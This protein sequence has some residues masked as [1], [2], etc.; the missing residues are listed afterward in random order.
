MATKYRT[1]SDALKEA[2]EGSGLS[3]VELE[4]KTG[5]ARQTMMR[6]VAGK[7]SMRL[8][9]ADGLAKFFKI[10]VVRRDTN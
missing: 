9:K 2:I 5:V 1:L 8:D 6:F 3:F 10:D 4:R 7:R